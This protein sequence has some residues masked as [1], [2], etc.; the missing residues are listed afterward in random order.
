[1]SEIKSI[2]DIAIA[3]TGNLDRKPELYFCEKCGKE[4]G[5]PTDYHGKNG[6][7][8]A[9]GGRPKGTLS[10]KTVTIME[11][12]K[13]FQERVA[14]MADKLIA[15]QASKALGEQHLMRIWYEGEGK[16]RRKNVEIVDD[17]EVIQ[18]YFEGTLDTSYGDEY[19]FM[20][21]KPAD[22]QAIE[23][24]LNRSFGKATEKIEIEG[25]FF[26]ADQLNIQ[27]VNPE[28]QNL[29][30]GTIEVI[31]EKTGDSETEH[32]TEPSTEPAE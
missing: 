31:A 1:M 29:D 21:T 32:Q 4:A 6:G 11:A 3:R 28:T 24:L 14:G 9:G 19:Y 23:S 10:P 8:R 30:D 7:P 18:Q 12:K 5:H 27:I 22:N 20:T 17:I 16:N 13:K 2:G 25:G 15:A 26:K